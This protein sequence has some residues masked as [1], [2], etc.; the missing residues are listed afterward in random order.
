MK[1]QK[2]SFLSSIVIA[3]SLV[4]SLFSLWQVYKTHQNEVLAQESRQQSLATVNDFKSSVIELNQ[5]VKSYIATSDPTYLLYYYDLLAME[6][7][8]KQMPKEYHSSAYWSSVIAGKMQHQMSEEK[9]F[10]FLEKMKQKGF[11]KTELQQ[12]QTIHTIAEKIKKIEQVAFA[13]TQGLYDPKTKAFTDDAVPDTQYAAQLVYGDEY[14]MLT[15]DLYTALDKLINMTQQRTESLVDDAEDALK[16][17]LVISIFLMSFT[18]LLILSSVLAV[19]KYLLSPIALLTSAAKQISNGQYISCIYPARWLEEFSQ[20]AHTFNNMAGDISED[21]Q[22]REKHK[23]ELEKARE[24]AED[25]ARTKA[26]FLANMSH[27]IRTPMN[28]IIGMSYLALQTDLNK[29]QREFIEQV[30][31]AAKS[32]LGI[33]NDIL[34]FSKIEAGKMTIEKKAFDLKTLIKELL[35]MHKY[36]AQ[37]KGIELIFDTSDKLLLDDAPYIIGD[38]LRISQILNNLLSNAIKFTESGFVKLSVN[39][40]K[41][42]DGTLHVAINVEDSGIGMSE[43][44][45]KKLFEEF[46]QADDSTS[47][48]YGGTG[49]GMAISKNLVQI[50][51]GD[52]SVK[53]VET[54]GTTFTL[55]FDFRTA[56]ID[57]SQLNTTEKATD[58]NVLKGIH[59]LLV[60]D[61]EMNQKLAIELL[62]NKG[63]QIT[64]AQNGQEAVDL[65]LANEP[66]FFEMVLMD[67]QM[68]LLSGDE[69]T[70]RIRENQSYDQLPIIAMTASVL[71]EEIEQYIQIGMQDYIGKPVEPEQLFETII[72]YTHSDSLQKDIVITEE[73]QDEIVIDGLNTQR[74]LK[75]SGNSQKL[76]LEM[77]H[78]FIDRYKNFENDLKTFIE[79]DDVS[80]AERL[81][82]T[83][84]GILGTIGAEGLQQKAESLEDALK[85]NDALYS[86]K[87][88]DEFKSYFDNL[89]NSIQQYLDT[90]SSESRT[91]DE[92]INEDMTWLQ[93]CLSGL[94]ENSFDAIEVWEEKKTSLSTKLS[95]VEIQDISNALA[96]FDFEQALKILEKVE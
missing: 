31:S 37:N 20:L 57:R 85:S 47:R 88:L 74:G 18:T 46:T 16:F 48:K 40:Q 22:R 80:S 53:S 72:K 21:I 75:Y 94:R 43:E 64:L 6:Q 61:N 60:E 33:I 86:L 11:A 78:D 70:K 2:I 68:P 28:A 50:M 55:T 41:N 65:V 35:A 92:P 42:D 8:M 45:L 76:Y 59:I 71:S 38:Q 56:Q 3:I 19:K 44:Q 23:K 63:I 10:S 66:D 83:V 58:H 93:E 34:D 36:Q 9:G 7:G 91:S 62:S 51:D 5:F 24:I 79:N 81:A 4:L 77:L 25:A 15:S 29:K 67:I 87:L 95:Q 69:A 1:L 54:K 13:A 17:W 90:L 84:K 27:E 49:L 82:H 73:K 12:L 39:S 32:L 26:M 30:N 52:L 96:N 14:I 89:V